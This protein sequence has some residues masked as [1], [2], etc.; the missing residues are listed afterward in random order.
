MVK[1]KQ[2]KISD[3]V[4][5]SGEPLLPII[6]VPKV[7]STFYAL[8]LTPH[9]QYGLTE[10]RLLILRV[11]ET[12]N[13]VICQ[14]KVGTPNHHFHCFFDSVDDEESVRQKVRDFNRVWWPDKDKRGDANK[15]YNLGEVRCMSACI[16][17]TLKDKN[18][19]YGDGIDKAA[20]DYYG[21]K[22]YPKYSAEEFSKELEKIK[23]KF[24]GDVHLK[25]RE[26]MIEVVKLKA[27]YRQ[28]INM[29]YIDQL[30]TSFWIHN[31]EHRAEFVVD[32][33]LRLI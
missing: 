10:V 21:K 17:Y 1:K 14:E 5:E 16:S 25:K 12:H 22:S 13:Y 11:F 29:R 24:K 2:S 20:L 27:R 32:E 4:E 23:E 9:G 18:F 33:Y 6:K 19:I 28:I 30:C 15:R 7:E 8:R 31:D 3:F 26:M